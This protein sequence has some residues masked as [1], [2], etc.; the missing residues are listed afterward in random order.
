MKDKYKGHTPPRRD[1]AWSMQ[2]SIGDADE[3]TTDIL[4]EGGYT[5][6]SDVDNDANAQLIADAPRLAEQNARMLTL[7]KIRCEH[8][9][10]GL[11]R[12]SFNIEAVCDEC[13]IKEMIKEVED[14][15]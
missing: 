15:R 1:G 8:C 3:D 9:E 6:A 5:V 7:M 4:G 12:F 10:R 11:R 13:R 14:E 2:V